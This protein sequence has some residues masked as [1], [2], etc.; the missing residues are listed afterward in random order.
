M[1]GLDI[2]I[3]SDSADA[4]AARDL[5]DALKEAGVPIATRG[6]SARVVLLRASSAPGRALLA[7]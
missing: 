2:V 6:G 4:F 5:R 1:R 7:R 3:P